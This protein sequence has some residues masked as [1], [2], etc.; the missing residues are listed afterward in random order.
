MARLVANPSLETLIVTIRELEA[1]LAML[2]GTANAVAENQGVAPPFP[3]RRSQRLET[4]AGADF[5]S[6]LAADSQD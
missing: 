4:P 5:E 6:E 2:K 3:A 1:R